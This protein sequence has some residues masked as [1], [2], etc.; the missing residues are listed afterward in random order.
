MC[1][2]VNMCWSANRNWS[3]KKKVVKPLINQ[4]HNGSRT[5][6]VFCYRLLLE[7]HNTFLLSATKLDFGYCLSAAKMYVYVLKC[8]FLR[9]IL[10]NENTKFNFLN[11]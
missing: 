5:S 3:L 4:L 10:P 2:R 9:Q 1:T 8:V 11:F 6:I 7:S